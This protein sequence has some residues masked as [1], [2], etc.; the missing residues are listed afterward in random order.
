[1][2]PRRHQYPDSIVWTLPRHHHATVGFR[3]F[4]QQRQDYNWVFTATRLQRQDYKFLIILGAE[5]FFDPNYQTDL[6][7]FKLWN[8]PIAA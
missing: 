8:M 5:N 7:F 3:N 6:N 4:A 2:A 1:M